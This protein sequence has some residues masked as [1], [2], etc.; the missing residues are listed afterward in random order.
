MSEVFLFYMTTR[1]NEPIGKIYIDVDKE[2]LPK[3]TV[4]FVQEESWKSIAIQRLETTFAKIYGYHIKSM[5][6][7]RKL[8][9]CESNSGNFENFWNEFTSSLYYVDP[10]MCYPYFNGFEFSCSI[11]G[12]IPLLLA[13]IVN[14][15]GGAFLEWGSPYDIVVGDFEETKFTVDRLGS[16]FTGESYSPKI[17][18]SGFSSDLI[19]SYCTYNS[20]RMPS[21]RRDKCVPSLCWVNWQSMLVQYELPVYAA[22][23]FV[24]NALQLSGTILRWSH[25][26]V[27]VPGLG[28]RS[29]CPFLHNPNFDNT[30]VYDEHVEGYRDLFAPIWVKKKRMNLAVIKNP[31][32]PDDNIKLFEMYLPDSVKLNNF[33]D[34]S[35]PVKGDYMYHATDSEFLENELKIHLGRMPVVNIENLLHLMVRFVL[36]AQDMWKTPT[37]Y[38]DYVNLDSKLLLICSL[39]LRGCSSDDLPAACRLCRQILI[40]ISRY[41]KNIDNIADLGYYFNPTIL[42]CIYTNIYD[43]F[44]IWDFRSARIFSDFGLDSEKW[45]KEELMGINKDIEWYD[46]VSDNNPTY[47]GIDQLFENIKRN[48]AFYKILNEQVSTGQSYSDP[49]TP[50]LF[51]RSIGDRFEYYERNEIRS[52]TDKLTRHNSTQKIDQFEFNLWEFALHAI[53]LHNFHEISPDDQSIRNMMTSYRRCKN[54]KRCLNFML[55]QSL[56]FTELPAEE[57]IVEEKPTPSENVPLSK[58]EVIKLDS[59]SE[60]DSET[61]E[62]SKQSSPLNDVKP[63]SPLKRPLENPTED[64][65]DSKII[66]IDE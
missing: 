10:E 19:G 42:I 37:N 18:L 55:I 51:E 29:G 25:G 7:M 45:T 15:L 60:E 65:N 28:S 26:T 13:M 61:E 27:R 14:R 38:K 59:E 30:D 17:A 58:K 22:S 48:I 53:E 3:G 39:V 40:Y 66:K 23:K 16:L 5:F 57:S 52:D 64:G 46:S 4:V 24:N 32:D 63:L 35:D 50:S 41:R 56:C 33:L 54:F 9:R 1:R 20:S 36:I 34:P 44:A 21:V 47:S 8:I 31:L 6:D 62:V 11:E 12:I 2:M 49:A 43:N